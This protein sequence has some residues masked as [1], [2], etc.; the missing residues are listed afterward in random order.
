M[1]VKAYRKALANELRSSTTDNKPIST[2]AA[3]GV[4]GVFD[5]EP[6]SLP[7][8]LSITVTTG[9]G[10]ATDWRYNVR[11]YGHIGQGSDPGLVYDAVDDIVESIEDLLG[12]EFG[13]ITW[14]F[15]YANDIEAWIATGSVERGRE[16]F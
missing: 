16:D 9:T 6:I 15:G 10:D 3:L 8:P 1:T 12:D 2:L 13:S 4:V 14:D 11:V 7:T 5:H